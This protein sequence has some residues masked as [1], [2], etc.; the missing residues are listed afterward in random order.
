MK[1]LLTFIVEEGAMEDSSPEEMRE[2]LE[3]WSAFDR[4]MTDA[5]VLIACEP[6]EESS[7]ATTLRLRSDDQPV[8]TDGPFAE[9]KEQLGGFCLLECGSREQ[10]LEWAR[11]VPMRS[12]AIELRPIMDLSQF[13]YESKTLSP[14]K[15]TA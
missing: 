6:L 7:A 1:Y 11:K 5:G 15:A 8:V 2:S 14:A 13:G 4:E 3:R 12:G 9:S 10:A